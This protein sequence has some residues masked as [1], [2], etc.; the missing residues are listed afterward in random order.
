MQR[1]APA[2]LLEVEHQRPLVAVEMG[3]FAGKLPAPR[4]SADGAQQISRRRLDLDDVGAVIREIQRRGRPHHHGGKVNH[5]D[6]GERTAAHV[7]A[8]VSMTSIR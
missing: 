6:A 1:P 5:A 2:L 3:E 4:G 7:V 8:V